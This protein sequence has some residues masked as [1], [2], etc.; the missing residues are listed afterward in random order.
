MPHLYVCVYV[1]M[2][3]Y[4]MCIYIYILIPGFCKPGSYRV[5]IPKPRN[6]LSQEHFADEREKGQKSGKCT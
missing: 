3:V 1:Y 4:Y 5:A 6:S 2:Y